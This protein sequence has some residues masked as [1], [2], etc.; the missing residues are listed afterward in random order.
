MNN[1]ELVKLR[2]KETVRRSIVKS[3]LYRIL[4]V[5]SD[6]VLL[7]FFSGKLSM[8][9][10]FAVVNN[11]YNTIA[12]FGYERIWDKIKWGKI[13]YKKGQVN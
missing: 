12:Y 10:G 7:Y 11:I 5:I 1:E 9:I 8:S 13:I 6:F 3:V 2:E 4:M